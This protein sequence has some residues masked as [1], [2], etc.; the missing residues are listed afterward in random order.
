MQYE[1]DVSELEAIFKARHAILIETLKHSKTKKGMREHLDQ[2]KSDKIVNMETLNVD[3]DDEDDTAS[4]LFSNRVPKKLQA[5]LMTVGMNK[6]DTV[7]SFEEIGWFD[8]D[9]EP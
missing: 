1:S 3:N 5:A 7:N 8:P 9:I 6:K 4:A 2:F